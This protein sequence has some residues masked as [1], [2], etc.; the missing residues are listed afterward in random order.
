MNNNKKIVLIAGGAGFIGFHLCKR[1]LKEGFHI[2]C[3]DD[4]ST[5]NLRNVSLLSELGDF[6]FRKHDITEPFNY[7]GDI[8]W[9]YNL[10]CPASPVKY[11]KDPIQTFMTNVEG[12]INMLRLASKHHA[13]I[14]LASTSEVYGNPLIH[15]QKENYWGN[16]N[17]DGIRSC[18]DEGK[19]AAETL[20]CDWHRMEGVDTRIVRIF[21][22]YGPNMSADDGRVVSNM[23]VQALDGSDI[24]VYG[25]GT[26]TRS[27]LYVDD[28][29]EGLVRIMDNGVPNTPINLGN[30]QERSINELAKTILKITG[31]KSRVVYRSLPEDDPLRRCPD[32]DKAK[33]CLQGWQP[34]V[35]LEEGLARTVDYFREIVVNPCYPLLHI[36]KETSECQ[37]HSI[38]Q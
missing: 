38:I 14:M 37:T 2:L 16:V 27:F 5:G 3:V 8:D 11:Q 10:A 31:S 23:I 28:L 30:P 6:E 20:F 35:T 19:R 22:T 12:S 18:Y 4:L 36:N 34:K 26:Q 29:I 9:I 33:L 21:N 1:L 7:D 17:P 25:D 32:I 13:R 15:P 24:T